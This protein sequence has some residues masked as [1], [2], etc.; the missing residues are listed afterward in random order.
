M[1]APVGTIILYAGTIPPGWVLCDGA[2]GTPDLRNR[3]VRGVISNNDLLGTGGVASHAHTMPTT[4]TRAAHAHGDLASASI[5]AST[6]TTTGTVSTGGVPN[7]AAPPSHTHAGGDI[8]IQSADSHSHTIGNT[9]SA[10][11]LPTHIK[12]YY[13]MKIA[14]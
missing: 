11:N 3:F 6:G 14:E 4:G 12:L 10:N 9:G 7:T 2:N 1:A 5:G 8:A 13:I